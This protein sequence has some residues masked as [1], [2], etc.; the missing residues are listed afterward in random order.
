MK[1]AEILRIKGS[2]VKT[3]PP[4]ET[5]LLASG[6]LRAE[7][8]GALVVSTDGNSIDGIISER[9]LAYGLAT[10]CERL[11]TIRISELMTR[12]VIV[13]SPEDSVTDVM[14]LMTQHRTRHVPVKDRDR[15]VGIISIGDVL[16]H[17][18]GELQEEADVLRDYAVAARR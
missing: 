13:C 10:H 9:D 15:L 12:A 8:I 1:V 11:P 2:F 16:K 17:R 14:K 5:A 7:Q 18:L 6:H 3:V 4:H